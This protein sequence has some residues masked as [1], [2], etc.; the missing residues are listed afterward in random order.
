[1]EIISEK[2]ITNGEI[3]VFRYET[4]TEGMEQWYMLVKLAE[5]STK[6]VR[7]MLIKYNFRNTS[8]TIMTNKAWRKAFTGAEYYTY[9]SAKKT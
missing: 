7:L 8:Y 3:T 6:P 1:M 9:F 2:G 5:R 4:T